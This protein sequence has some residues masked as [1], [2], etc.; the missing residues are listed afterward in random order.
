M[1]RCGLS[2]RRLV[3]FHIL[4]SLLVAGAAVIGGLCFAENYARFADS[5]V[6]FGKSVVGFFCYVFELPTSAV[7]P[8]SSPPLDLGITEIIPSTPDGFVARCKSFA[9]LF[10]S[11]DNFFNYLFFLLNALRTFSYVV[12]MTLPLLCCVVGLAVIVLTNKPQNN[13]YGKESYPLRLWKKFVVKFVLPVKHWFRDAVRFSRRY[14]AYRAAFVIIW[15]FSLNLPTILVGFLAFYFYFAYSF[16]FISLYKNVVKLFSDLKPF[17]TFMPW[18]AYVIAAI[19]I[20]G[21]IRRY[22]GYNRLVNLENRNKGFINSLPITTLTVGTMGCGKTTQLT[23]MALSIQQIFR[24]KAFDLLMENDLKFHYFPWQLFE[25]DLKRGMRSGGVYNLASCR[26]FVRSK[27]LKFLRRPQKRNIWFYDFYHFPLMYDDDLKLVTLFDVL[28]TYAQL[29][30]I[31]VVKSS[32]IVGNYSIR[33]DARLSDTGNFPMWDNDF[34][35]RD[36]RA[37]DFASRHSHILDFDTLRLGKKMI[38]NNPNAGSFEF[39]VVTITEAGKERGNQ[40]E[41]EG[42]KKTDA[43]PNQKNDGFNKY[44][45][46]CRHPSTVDNYPFVKIC[47][48]EQRPES[49]GAD[50][51][52]LCQIVHI[53]EKSDVRLAMPWYGF[54][55]W[56]HN[57]FFGG[58]IKRYVGHRNRRGDMTLRSHLCHALAAKIHNRHT[59][60]YN[61]FGFAVQSVEVEDGTQDGRYREAKYYIMNKKIYSRR[62]STD[63]FKEYFARNSLRT[64]GGITAYPE[65]AAERATIDEL[66]SQNSHFINDID[67]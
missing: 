4:F 23:D 48:D 54:E 30:F 61:M 52:E 56:L 50:A 16:D 31:Y 62:Y 21:V 57:K 15:A 11:A 24:D 60:I 63:C 8:A 33:D 49:L 2:K 29:F 64:R 7:P 5:C 17:F 65:Y 45:K 59:R 58:L 1:E 51:R 43:T 9:G 22:I 28:E 10:F 34:F 44:V 53:R 41:Q 35:I 46:M 25:N 42:Q 3:I 18:W 20:L 47:M 27:E 19:L 32:L 6:S 14:K 36:S 38:A 67:N 66:R 40:K 37:E 12:M 39:G 55:V 13:D 26:R